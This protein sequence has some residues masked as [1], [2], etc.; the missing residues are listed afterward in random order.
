MQK[1]AFIIHGWDGYPEEGWFPWLKNE[2]EK[3][4]FVVQVP[5]MPNTSEPRIGEWV[6]HLKN[7]VGMP[8]ENTYFVG[9]S[10]GCQTILRYLE[11]LNEGKR[12]GGAVFVAGWFT[13]TNLETDKEK[14]IAEPWLNQLI[15]L[16]KVK[17]RTSNFIA[18]FSNNDP[19][20]P[21]ENQ[22]IFKDKL[23]TRIIIENRKGHFS[24]ADGIDNLPSALEAVLEIARR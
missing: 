16:N 12:V 23:G 4:E 8:D 7:L 21:A 2:L 17:E 15:N 3:K 11:S 14:E 24:G 9:H 10:I 20:V 13:L 1:R 18:I 22:N 5:K 19:F 6:D